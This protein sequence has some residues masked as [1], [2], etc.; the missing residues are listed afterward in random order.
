ML[1]DTTIPLFSGFP[2]G[3]QQQGGDCLRRLLAQRGSR[4]GT[5]SPP[6]PNRRSTIPDIRVERTESD[7]A[8][9]QGPEGPCKLTIHKKMH[10]RFL[11]VVAKGA[12]FVIRD[13][14]ASKEVGNRDFVMRE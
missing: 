7:P 1:K 3:E 11:N 8:G 10:R 14:S 9:D 6:G 12:P 13:V 4:S 5:L 2:H